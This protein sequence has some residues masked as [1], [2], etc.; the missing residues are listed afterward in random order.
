MKNRNNEDISQ[1]QYRQEFG[2]EDKYLLRYKSNKYIVFI[3]YENDID[4]IDNR[5]KEKIWETDDLKKFE[6]YSAKLDKAQALPCQNLEDEINMSFKRMLGAGYVLMLEKNFDLIDEIIDDAEKYL[7]QRNIEA[8]RLL[9]LKSSVISLSI[10]VLIV[11]ISIFFIKKY[12]CF[13]IGS[14]MGVVGAFASI[15]TR[16][17]KICYTGLASKKL[18]CFESVTRL[19]TGGIFALIALLCIKTGILFSNINTG[20]NPCLYAL[21]GFI[22]GFSERLIPSLIEKITIKN[23]KGNE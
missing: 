8:S 19:L 7:R 20:S 2:I 14:T 5:E 9:F 3:D 6:I 22:A 16:Y 11:L 23:E 4:W 10:I 18:H 12:N 13:I 1:K 17:G 15:W 21:S